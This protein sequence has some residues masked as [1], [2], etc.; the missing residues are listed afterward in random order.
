MKGNEALRDFLSRLNDDDLEMLFNALC[1][2]NPL[3]AQEMVWEMTE[4]RS[5]RAFEKEEAAEALREDAAERRRSARASY[6]EDI[7]SEWETE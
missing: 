2:G 1:L 5:R 3:N 4:E 6:Y 7:A